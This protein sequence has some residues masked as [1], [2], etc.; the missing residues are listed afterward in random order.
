MKCPECQAENSDDAEFCSLCFVRFKFEI[1]PG[2]VDA[3]ASEMEKKHAGA[4]I[5]CPS[6][7]ELSP[8]DSPFCLR[9]AFV[10]DD[11]DSLMIEEA[12]VERVSRERA[13]AR[14]EE[15]KE[16]I[17]APMVITAES[18]GDE[19]MRHM[20]DVLDG[21][22]ASVIQ[23]SGSNAI[24]HALKL[25]ALLGEDYTK[26]GMELCLRVKLMSEGTVVDLDDVELEM[27]IEAR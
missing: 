22:Y 18:A 23:G 3:A 12:E 14:Q 6:C 21:G 26:R 1:R 25:I 2:E 4:R 9:C 17:G 20:Q 10:F 24:T 8:L 19:V 15:M 16:V 13:E 7:G 11:I 27:I 5:E